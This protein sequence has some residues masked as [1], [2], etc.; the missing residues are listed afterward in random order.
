VAIRVLGSA[1]GIGVATQVAVDGAGGL[2]TVPDGDRDSALVEGAMS[3]PAKTPLAPG[4]H[5]PC[6]PVIEALVYG[7]GPARPRGSDRSA[8]LAEGQYERVGFDALELTGRLREAGFVEGHLF[9]G[10]DVPGFDGLL[11]R[12]E[13][14][15]G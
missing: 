10:H 6:P 11:D 7:A 12:G 5:L 8:V 15:D 1:G 14:L 3:P 2:L 9:D 4:H 13:P